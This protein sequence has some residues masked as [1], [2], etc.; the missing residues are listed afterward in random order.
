MENVDLFQI[1]DDWKLNLSAKEEA[2]ADADVL[3]IDMLDEDLTWTSMP[4]AAYRPKN[5]L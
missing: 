5:G 1:S 2:E 3:P 4:T